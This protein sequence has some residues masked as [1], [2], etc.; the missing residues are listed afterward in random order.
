MMNK[1]RTHLDFLYHLLSKRT[2][3]SG[4][5]DGHVFSAAVLTADPIE[6]AC[7]ILDITTVQIS[8][9]RFT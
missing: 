5:S 7:A 3:F 9:K 4:N 8:L 6:R 1:W 2:D